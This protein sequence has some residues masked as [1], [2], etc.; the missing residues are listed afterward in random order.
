MGQFGPGTGIVSGQGKPSTAGMKYIP[1]KNLRSIPLDGK[2]V[3]LVFDNPGEG[4][5]QIIVERV[6]EEGRER[7]LMAT[8]DG[9]FTDQVSIH[10]GHEARQEVKI[11]ANNEL[12]GFALRASL[13][14]EESTGK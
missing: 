9:S 1:L 11:E 10:L 3:N 14:I 5:H 2:T 7:V 6:G 4:N 13:V 8:G 12:D